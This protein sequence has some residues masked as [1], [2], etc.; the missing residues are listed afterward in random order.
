M[1]LKVKLP[2]ILEVD[3][4]GAV[5]LANNYS[6]GGRTKHFQTRQLF[7]RQLK[8]DGMIKVIWKSGI[9]NDADLFTK[10]LSAEPFHRHTKVYCGKDEYYESELSK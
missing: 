9:E 6:V 2:M 3:N 8:E 10:N 5:D 1:K 7:L 4:K